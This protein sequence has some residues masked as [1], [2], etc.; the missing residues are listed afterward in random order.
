MDDTPDIRDELP[1]ELLP[2]EFERFLLAYQFIVHETPFQERLDHLYRLLEGEGDDQAA[3]REFD[4]FT[5]AV[6]ADFRGRAELARFD[7]MPEEPE[8]LIHIKHRF[9]VQAMI[10]ALEGKD[11]EE[12]GREFDHLEQN[13]HDAVKR[14]EKDLQDGL[15]FADDFLLAREDHFITHYFPELLDEIREEA[16]Q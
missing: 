5:D 12:R 8:E 4:E 10:A 16:G 11:D 3:D 9:A 7:F 2:D 1:E 14:A 6:I 15:E 13:A